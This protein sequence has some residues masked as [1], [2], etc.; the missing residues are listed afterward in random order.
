VFPS[1]PQA[2]LPQAA[3]TGTSPGPVPVH[4]HV[5]HPSLAKEKPDAVHRYV[6]SS[7]PQADAP[8]AA[9]TRPPSGP[10]PVQLHPES[11]SPA[12]GA[13][14]PSL[15]KEKPD[16]LQEYVFP[17]SPHAVAPQ[18]AVTGTPPGPVPVQ[19][20][21]ESTAPES[22]V[23]QPSAENAK[24]DALQE[25]VFPSSPHAVA[26]Q[27]AVTGTPPGPVPMQLHPESTAP[28]SGVE[29]P[30]AENAKPDALQEY[31]FSSS[32]Q[33]VVPQ[34]AVTGTPPGP[35]PMQLQLGHPALENAKP[36]E[37]HK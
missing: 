30:S 21:P 8:Q 27:A 19:L 32:P 13:E 28:A 16:A 31:V 9:V 34:A 17:S 6:F 5:G 3:V 37:L 23:E 15:E 18:A 1:S 26:P 4:V 24:P 33:A 22:G 2:L 10:V 25:Y 20:H 11:T 12:S 29:Q 7:L 36:L 35:V 14:Q